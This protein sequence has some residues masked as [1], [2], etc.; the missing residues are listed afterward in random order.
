MTATA[1]AG[2]AAPRMGPV[3]TALRLGALFG[4]SVF[5]VTAAAVA[6]PEIARELHAGPAE[7]AWVLT[8]HALALGVGTAVFGRLADGWGTRA[9]LLI[10]A[11]VLAAGAVVC[12]AA[13]SLGV[14][15]A[16]R[17]VLAA[18]SGGTAAVGAALLAG[19]EPADRPRV[20]AGYGAVMAVFASAATLA[21][22]AVTTWLSWRVTV[23]LP[24]LSVAA[25]PFCLG[26]ARRPGSRRF[27]DAAGAAA[28]TAAVSAMLVLIQARTL[29]LGGTVVAALA[30]ALVLS[31]GALAWRVARRPDGFVPHPVLGE[32]GYRI[33]AV[34]GAGVFGGLFAAMYVVPQVLAGE[35]GWNVLKIGAAL[36]PGAVV[37]AALA[38]RAGSLGARGGRLLLAGTALAAA[39]ALAAASTGEGGPWPPVVAAS[40]CLAAFAVTQ[41]VIT[42]EVSARLPM[43]LRGAGMGLLNLTFFV[44]GGVG[45]ALAGALAE[46]R[47]PSPILAVTALFPLTAAALATARRST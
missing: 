13:P 1:E 30:A 21:G 4:P 12:A 15:V 37:G 5:G 26:L 43:P 35:H 45:S 42:G 9:T 25:V 17:L 29:D 32:A 44:G 3:P 8:A 36:L 11:A 38:R 2:V 6:L 10:A 28:L 46:S 18:G 23:V 14:L 31:G 33:S 24:V 16:G 20:L 7:V 19:V 47:S 41:V 34:I 22:G 27:V 40:L 39:A